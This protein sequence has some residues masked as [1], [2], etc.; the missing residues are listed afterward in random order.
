MKQLADIDSQN[1]STLICNHLI[2][3]SCGVIDRDYGRLRN[4]HLCS[5]CGVASEAGRLVFPITIHI[6]VDLVQQVYHSE[7]RVGPLDGPQSA[8]IGSVLYYC[9]LREALLT[10]TLTNNMRARNVPESLISNLLDSNRLANQRFG[11]LFSSVFDMSWEA[12]VTEIS[13]KEGFDFRGVSKLMRTATESRNKF[14]HEGRAWAVTRDF[15]TQCVNSM[16]EMVDLF[17]AI[18]N[19]HT[20][21]ILSNTNRRDQ[22]RGDEA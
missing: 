2:C 1:A 19:R 4:G 8:D 16:A 12:A 6:L 14:L 9:T 7:S 3:R 21:P 10:S 11:G 15:A 17:V 18:H 22:S 5:T 20:H 13:Q